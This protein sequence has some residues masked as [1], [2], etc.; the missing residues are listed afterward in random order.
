MFA[1]A[2]R[3]QSPADDARDDSAVPV[4]VVDQSPRAL[5][6]VVGSDGTFPHQSLLESSLR[7]DRKYG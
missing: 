5:L 6:P 1:D 4:Y 2:T 7:E 3:D